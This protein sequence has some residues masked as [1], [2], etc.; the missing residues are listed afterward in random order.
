MGVTKTQQAS[1][2]YLLNI[3]KVK[4][5]NGRIRRKAASLTEITAG[6]QLHELFCYDSETESFVPDS[7]GDLIKSSRRL[8]YATR[9][10]GISDMAQDI[11]KRMELLQKC[12][13]EKAYGIEK[14]F[15][16]I[17]KYYKVSNPTK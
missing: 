14:V 5:R 15:E 1:I 7:I 16:I 13:N 6:P 17:S 4:A 8:K 2:N 3:Q 10:L 11:Q 9:F 12:V